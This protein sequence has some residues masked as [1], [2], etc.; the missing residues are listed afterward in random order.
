M[1]PKLDQNY[2]RPSE[3]QVLTEY[4]KA[5]SYLTI[6]PAAR[7]AKENQILRIDKSNYEIIRK[8]LDEIKEV[9]KRP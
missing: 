2:F 6:D 7:L 5:E 9:L 8:E 4:L 1:L 3:D